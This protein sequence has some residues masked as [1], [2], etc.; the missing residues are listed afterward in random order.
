MQRSRLPDN[1]NSRKKGTLKE[2][3]DAGGHE[4]NTSTTTNSGHN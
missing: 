1:V 3:E 2:G 4:N